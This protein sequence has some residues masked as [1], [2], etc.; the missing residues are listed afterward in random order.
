MVFGPFQSKPV[1]ALYQELFSSTFT[2]TTAGMKLRVDV[3]GTFLSYNV[4][5]SDKIGVAEKKTAG[6]LCC[7]P[8]QA[9]H[10]S[11]CDD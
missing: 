6:G 1:I 10:L 3:D 8:K 5:L 2:S 4:L 11:A 7:P 9:W